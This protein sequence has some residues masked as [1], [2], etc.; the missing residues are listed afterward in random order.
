MQ[1][2]VPVVGACFFTKLETNKLLMDLLLKK[3][4]KLLVGHVG[5][6][7][8][9]EWHI[10]SSRWRG[11]ICSAREGDAEKAKVNDSKVN[12]NA[13]VNEQVHT[14]LLHIIFHFG[15]WAF[16]PQKLTR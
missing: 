16:I 15:L 14:H 10:S 1:Q 13:K 4:K 9:V 2:Y 5:N 12:E 7:W 6:P 8:H 3:R 11:A